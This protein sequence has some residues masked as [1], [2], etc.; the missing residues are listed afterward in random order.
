[1]TCYFQEPSDGPEFLGLD[2]VKVGQTA[3][4]Y[5]VTARKTDGSVTSFPAG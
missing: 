2:P 5:C 1:M 3:A 4:Q